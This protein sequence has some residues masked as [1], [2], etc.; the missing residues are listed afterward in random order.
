MKAL[1]KKPGQYW[2]QIEIPN[3]LKALQN[4]VGGDIETVRIKTDATIICNEEGLIRDLPRND[5][6]G[7]I[8]RGTIL[9]V[10]IKR[11]EFCDIPESAIELFLSRR[12]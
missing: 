7:H 11:D 8:W 9:M 10:G 2:E 5:F 4:E 12:S 3:T 6:L 1:R